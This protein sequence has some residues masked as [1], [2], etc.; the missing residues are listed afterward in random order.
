MIASRKPSQFKTFTNSST[1]SAALRVTSSTPPANP[2]RPHL[3][4]SERA[5]APALFGFRTTLIPSCL[6]LSL[7]DMIANRVADQIAH[8]MAIEAPHDVGPVGLDRFH[9]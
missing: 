6:A 3:R 8:R 5:S 2:L 7:D 1:T 9:A 4:Q